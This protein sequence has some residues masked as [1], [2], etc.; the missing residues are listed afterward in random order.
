MTIKKIEAKQNNKKSIF[1][2]ENQELR[3]FSLLAISFL[4][5]S[6]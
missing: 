3:S 6:S 5:L 2:N 1:P 4:P